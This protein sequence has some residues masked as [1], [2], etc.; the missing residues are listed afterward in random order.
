LET[1]LEQKQNERLDKNSKVWSNFNGDLGMINGIRQTSDASAA[2]GWLSSSKLASH[3]TSSDATQNAALLSTHD[4]ST[5]DLHAGFG[6]DTISA[7]T[8]SMQTLGYGI[9]AAKK[10]VPTYEELREQNQEQLEELRDKQTASAQTV[11]T[12]RTSGG[13]NA[14][15][16]SASIINGITNALETT[17]ARLS[18]AASYENI[19]KATLQT[20]GQ[21]EDDANNKSGGNTTVQFTLNVLV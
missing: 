21:K 10:V 3:Q 13:Q 4:A 9:D 14:A 11:I 7:P 15:K 2:I 5:Q 19:S 16:N 20:I 17:Q 12:A 1:S 18:G 6:E 8:A